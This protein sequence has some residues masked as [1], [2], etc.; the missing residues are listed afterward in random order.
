MTLLMTGGAGFLG[1]HL[2]REHLLAGRHVTVLADPD[3]V[4][5]RERVE[6][7]LAADGAIGRLPARLR[8]LLAVVDVNTTHH[9]LGLSPLQERALAARA[10]EL[11]HVPTSVVPSGHDTD[12]WPT[13]VSG[14]EN[15]LRF[16]ARLHP[17]A[18]LR[19]VS[20]AFV[21][22]RT[23]TGTF[24]EQHSAEVAEFESS[25]ERAKHMTEGLVRRWANRH[26]RGALIVRP[27]ILVPGPLPADALPEHPLRVLGR[28]IAGIVAQA[29][30]R[31][32]RLLLRIFAEPRAFLNL[33]QAGWAARTMLRLGERVTGPGTH[34]VHVVHPTDT[35]VRT[36]F[37]A[38]EDVRRVRLRMTPTEPAEPTRAERAFYERAAGFLPYLHHR[39]R[40]DDAALR[41]HGV[42]VAPPAAIDRAYLRDVVAA[43]LST[44]WGRGLAAAA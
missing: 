36:I 9:S 20:T 31:S 25:A 34:T 44:G 8:D 35:P 19:H 12:V 10:T 4:P 1:L 43:D 39:R 2:V 33:L 6:R 38:I 14:T 21:A 17:A 13:T 40:F 24:L 22:G 29:P 26:G 37:Q 5:A 15:V 41:R 32:S 30:A 16:A 7:F 28:T 3:D 18:P 11:W 23:R 42:E 27:G